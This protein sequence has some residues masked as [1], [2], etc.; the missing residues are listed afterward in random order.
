MLEVVLRR[1]NRTGDVDLFD[2]A[3]LVRKYYKHVQFVETW[4]PCRNR[5]GF[6][7]FFFQYSLRYPS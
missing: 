3:T 1:S 4:T 7:R 6:K 5:Q 2:P